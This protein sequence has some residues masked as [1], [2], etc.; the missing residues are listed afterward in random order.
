MGSKINTK[1]FIRTYRNKQHI[2]KI[3][4]ELSVSREIEF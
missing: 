4:F 3:C 1:Y 2:E